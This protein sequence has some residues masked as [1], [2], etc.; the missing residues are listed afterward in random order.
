MAT[1]R[2]VPKESIEKARQLLLLEVYCEQ[3]DDRFV[4]REA[5]K[6]LLAPLIAARESGLS[7]EDIARVFG[8]AG[9]ELTAATLRTYYFELKTEAELA[10]AARQHAERVTQTRRTIEQ[11]LLEKHNQHAD[12]LALAHA[13]RRN[14]SA[15]LFDALAPTD[16]GEERPTQESKLRAKEPA[17]A[18]GR[19]AR[20]P[21]AAAAPAPALPPEPALV[22]RDGEPLGHRSVEPVTTAPK[23]TGRKTS[24]QELEVR[25]D[26]ATA[27][28][29][30]LEE[31]EKR[32]L[33]TDERTTLEE[34]LVLKDDLVMYV[35]GRPFRGALS[36]KQIHLLR[37]VGKIIAPTSGRSSA[38]F[39]RMPSTL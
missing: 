11:K 20:P 8:K 21:T 4:K 35:S 29:L 13:T 12:K 5:V 27:D 36:K 14:Q 33:A 28:A 9:L 18:E 15:V 10:T 22:G 37:S 30:T 16:E 38:D 6:Q 17:P 26:E 25:E 3:T 39:V 32:S 19:R 1:L 23:E 24:S 31:I 7:F 2:R 34:D